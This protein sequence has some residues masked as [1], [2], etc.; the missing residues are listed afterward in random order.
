MVRI[1]ATNWGWKM[2]DETLVPVM[3][4][5]VIAQNSLTNAIRC[6]C[7]VSK[8][9]FYHL[10]ILLSSRISTTECNFGEDLLGTFVNTTCNLRLEFIKYIRYCFW[11]YSL[12]LKMLKLPYLHMI[13]IEYSM[14]GKFSFYFYELEV[15]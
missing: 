7:K 1:L 10:K 9:Y 6:K 4:D 8:I 12:F 2:Q 5:L 14:T 15:T 3:T 13:Q 11:S